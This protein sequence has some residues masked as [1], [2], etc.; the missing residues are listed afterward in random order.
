MNIKVYEAKKEP[1]KIC[2]EKDSIFLPIC[3]ID[4]ERK[5]F[6][7]CPDCRDKVPY[8]VIPV[9]MTL[10]EGYYYFNGEWHPGGKSEEM[11]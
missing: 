7:V 1:C 3:V 9:K 10:G 2:N 6:P 4:G 8:P 11:A 5:M